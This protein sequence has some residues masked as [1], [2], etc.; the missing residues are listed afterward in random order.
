MIWQ[1]IRVNYGPRFGSGVARMHVPANVRRG[2]IMIPGFAR[3]TDEPKFMELARVFSEREVAVFALDLLGA[4]DRVAFEQ[5]TIEQMAHQVEVAKY[6]AQFRANIRRWSYVCHSL[7]AAVLARALI[8]P[9]FVNDDAWR[10][11]LLA[12]A[13]NQSELMRYYSAHGTAS[14][15][16]DT[17]YR[18]S[19]RRFNGMP[20]LREHASRV[21]YVFGSEDTKAPRV[22]LGEI[23]K[24]SRVVT[25]KGADHELETLEALQVWVKLAAKFLCV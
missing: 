20:V 5:Y 23:P 17:P 24:E 2:V 19:V 25:V 3:T 22:L 16:L 14:S 4:G 1:T 7:G 9:E 13:A 11:V 6:V 21:M 8:R 12:P 15:V 10:A 18:T